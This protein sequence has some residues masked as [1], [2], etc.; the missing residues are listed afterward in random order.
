MIDTKILRETPEKIRA[1]LENRNIMDFPLDELLSLDAK[2][3]ELITMNQKL[4]EERNR[5]SL[6]ISRAK[7]AGNEEQTL[8]IIAQM[9]KTSDEI[10]ENDKQ[11]ESI[12]QNFELLLSTVPNFIDAEVPIGKDESANREISRWGETHLGKEDHIDISAKYDLIDVERAAKTSGARF[13]FLKRDLVRLNYA[14]ISYA[15]DFLR[16]RGFILI[17]PPYMLKRE[18]I[19]GAVILGDFE[20]VIYK[21]ENEDLYL[22]GTSEHAIAS[23]HMKE[24]F[25]PDTLPLLYAGISPCFRKE[26]GAHGRDTKG[27][28]R[29]HQ[30]EK[31]EQFVFCEPSRSQQEHRK[32]LENAE[33][34]L[35]TLGI[36]YR[37]MLLSSGDMGKV[38]AKTFDLEGW[39]P[40]QGKYRELISCSNC[41]DF[42]SRA[43]GIKYREKPHEESQFVHT[44]NS[45][46]VATERTIV[47]LI[48]NY[49]DPGSGNIRIPP[50]LVDYMNGQTEITRSASPS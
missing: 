5:Y 37:V 29:V 8:A 46:L 27:I 44:L 1:N 14:L 3:R 34:F 23:M 30:F 22:I 17:Q 35:Q 25:L 18:A 43:L 10:T 36:P 6:E 20:D 16:K 48:E 28:F 2:R 38:A 24:I 45:T 39:I 49:Y 40:S 42:Q 41:T 19:S 13:Y 47:A 26:A 33:Q 9:K 21:I 31:V 32:L 11:I 7:R 12:A 4:K 15:L 50:I